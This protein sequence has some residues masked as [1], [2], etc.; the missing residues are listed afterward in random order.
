ME[1][2][3]FS[4]EAGDGIAIIALNRPDKLNSLTQI[5]YRENTPPST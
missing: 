2:S 1:Y 4:H 3:C 5:F